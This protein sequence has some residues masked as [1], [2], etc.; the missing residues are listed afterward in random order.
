MAE[1][2][3]TL[4]VCVNGHRYYKSSDCPVCPVCEN[5]SKPEGG[6]LSL[7]SA[8]ARRALEGNGIATLQKLSQYSEKEILAFHGV[9]PSAIPILD[10][11]LK[12]EKLSFRKKEK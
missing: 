6:F 2:K 12:K 11:A 10:K 8:P 5:E 7:L 3:G 9:G 1:K 4:R